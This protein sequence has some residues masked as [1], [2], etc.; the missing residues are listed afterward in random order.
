MSRSK[1]PVIFLTILALFLLGT[2]IVLST[3]SYHLAID[4][5]AYLTDIEVPPSAGADNSIEALEKERIP[6]IIHQ[7]WKTDVL[8]DRWNAV[9]NTCR[10]LMPDYE[11]MLWTDESS[12]DFIAREYSWFLPT[13]D[14]YKYPI[15]RADAIRYFVLHH[16]GGIY[17]DLDVGCLRPLDSLLV[18]PVIL[19]RTIPVG[20]S[21]DLMFAAKGHP[22][23]AQTIHNLVTFDHDY[24][25]NYPTVMF[26]TGPMFISAQYGI[27]TASHPSGSN[28]AYPG[29]EVRILS[30]ALYGKNAK[31][32][33]APHAFFSHHYGSSWHA[34]DA[35]FVTFLGKWGTILMRLGCVVLV[36]GLV[37]VYWRKKTSKGQ[38]SLRRRL[39]SIR[40]DFLLPRG[41][42]W[43]ST[44]LPTTATAGAPTSSSTSTSHHRR[45]GHSPSDLEYFS[46]PPRPV[47]VPIHDSSRSSSPS[48]SC[49]SM[50][51]SSS[52]PSDPPSPSSDDSAPSHHAA[53]GFLFPLPFD[54]RATAASSSS[55]VSLPNGTERS[56][57][58]RA[59]N[60]VVGAFRRAGTWVVGVPT[61]LFASTSSSPRGVG[62]TVTRTRT[63]TIVRLPAILATTHGGTA[64]GV[65]SRNS[66][67]GGIGVGV[68]A[69]ATAIGA[70]AEAISAAAL[71]KAREAGFILPLLNNAG[72]GVGFGVGGGGRSSRWHPH[73][74]S[75]VES[76]SE[77]SSTPV[78]EARPS[79]PAGGIAD[80]EAG[81]GIGSGA[82]VLGV[83]DTGGGGGSGSALEVVGS[84]ALGVGGEARRTRRISTCAGTDSPPPY[85]SP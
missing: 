82:G 48:A 78:L 72:L 27:Y 30:K 75:D 80:V 36:V 42:F 37:R 46:Y 84:D 29:G 61:Y 14:G 51:P 52:A 32:G 76:S 74:D 1:A 28:A 54:I 39:L 47:H 64:A 58:E 8:P 31:P 79:A 13:F 83:S 53:A 16:Y 85:G 71:A 23:M 38:S 63:G 77:G 43:D 7:T 35:W 20:V 73:T 19:P 21:N 69:A 4:P 45:H 22:F 3:V 70:S 17:L 9:S 33:E 81:H 60:S 26:S 34:D 65:S 2:V 59:R 25:L 62:A 18:Y 40:Y 41:Y 55:T 66:G 67:H 50:T 5:T 11:Y 49:G 57:T 6:R 68:G 15:Q 44:V 56:R 10:K 24:I 12:R